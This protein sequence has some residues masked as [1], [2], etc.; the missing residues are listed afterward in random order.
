[1][2]PR[3]C[4]AAL[5]AALAL[6]GL[7]GCGGDGGEIRIGVLSDCLGPIGPFND[8]AVGAAE[9]PLLE[10][11]AR[12]VGSKATSGIKSARVAGKRVTFLTGC[13]SFGE[14][15]RLISEAR[16][17]LEKEGVDVL[18]GPM[19]ESEGL[20]VRDIARRNPRVTF[21]LPQ[22]RTQEVTL[23]DPATNV[24]RFHPDNAQ[25]T[26][27]LGSYAYHSLGWRTAAVV[28]EDFVMSWTGAAG[29]VAEFCALGGRIVS[30]LW[31]PAGQQ[32]GN[33]VAKLPVVDGVALIPGEAFL[34]VSEFL[35]AYARLHPDIS[36]RLVLGPETLILGRAQVA[37]FAPEV[38]ASDLAPY[39][40]GNP[41]WRR[42]RRELRRYFPGLVPPQS[43]PAEFPIVV[44]LR[45]AM[46]ATLQAL[47]EVDGDLSGGEARFKAALARL[48]LNGPT[49]H[50]RLDANHQAIAATYLNRVSRDAK[51]KPVLRTI[52]VVPNVEQTFGGYF[53][54]TTPPP[55]TTTPACRRATPPPWARASR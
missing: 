52:R 46:E 54:G 9:L 33:L 39:D 37:R 55:T 53:N 14:Y 15:R 47:E 21:V 43:A 2:G 25:Q 32:P 30:R 24:F 38:V 6:A 50:I 16:R 49:G 11:G 23:H 35:K 3:R 5:V 10:R 34:D 42:I 48:D 44:S 7:V 27:G 28:G 18:I 13:T 8:L 1:M 17:L 26:A 51:G 45:N 36:R 41:L 40:A 22:S 29:F 19:A 12:L 31:T 4:C 20:I